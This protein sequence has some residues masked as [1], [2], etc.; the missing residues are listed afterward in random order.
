MQDLQK[1]LK[2]LRLNA[3]ECQRISDCLAVEG[4]LGLFPFQI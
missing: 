2:S 3:A 4:W 1:H